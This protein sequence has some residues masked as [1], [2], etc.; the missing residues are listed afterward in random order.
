MKHRTPRAY[1]G[2]SLALWV[3]TSQTCSRARPG[4]ARNKLYLR[5]WGE[6]WALSSAW[7]ERKIN[8]TKIADNNLQ[9]TLCRREIFPPVKSPVKLSTVEVLDRKFLLKCNQVI[10]L[11]EKV[12]KFNFGEWTFNSN[13][14]FVW[15]KLY[16]VLVCLNQFFVFYTEIK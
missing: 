13:S 16:K 2:G 9:E 1:G 11:N 8:Q 5:C 15:G 12:K 3:I 14:C 4:Q 10:K 7:S 6:L